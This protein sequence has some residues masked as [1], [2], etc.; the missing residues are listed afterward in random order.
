[1]EKRKKAKAEEFFTINPKESS[2]YKQKGLTK[3]G[4]GCVFSVFSAIF[5]TF[6]FCV[7]GRNFSYIYYEAKGFLCIY[8]QEKKE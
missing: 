2:F 8:G 6:Y 5:E 3:K 1:M 4:T 7:C